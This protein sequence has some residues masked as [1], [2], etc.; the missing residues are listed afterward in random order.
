MTA[1]RGLFWPLLLI[2]I[3]AIFL[4]ANLGFIGRVSVLALFSLWPLILILLGIDIA[5]GRRWPLAALALDVA[6]LAGGIALVAAQPSYP[7]LF[8]FGAPASFGP[9][10]THVSVPRGSAQSLTF[11][12]NG[13]AG[14]FNLSGGATDLVEAT[15]DREDL[16]IRSS[17]TDRVDVRI[18][19]SDRGIRF[20]P[21]TPAHVDA[22][23]ASDVPTSLDMDAGAGEFVV[24]LRDVKLTDAHI[25][26]GAA[27]LRVVLP[28]PNGDVSIAISAGA[29]SVVIEV[30]EG[31]EA[32]VNTSGAII[33]SRSENPRVAANETAGYASARDRVTVRVTAGASSVVIR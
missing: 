7:Q 31:V 17:G 25:D 13:G 9:G 2:V 15:S 10:Q 19:Q 26:V 23:L 22:R 16:R 14:T 5:I 4:L 24:D 28:K 27:S 32:R 6:I 12:L 30:P 1:R 3:G 8:T 20:G 29:S 18:D 11:H 21:N 33:S